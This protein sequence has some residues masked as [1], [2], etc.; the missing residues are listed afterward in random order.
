MSESA[1]QL[2]TDHFGAGRVHQ[3]GAVWATGEGG[4]SDQ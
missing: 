1:W 3:S 4:A 2:L